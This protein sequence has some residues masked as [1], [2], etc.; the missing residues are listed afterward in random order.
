MKLIR[1]LALI[2]AIAA[3]WAAPAAI[4]ASNQTD[5]APAEAPRAVMPSLKYEFDPVVD[6][7]QVTHGFKIRNEGNAELAI[8]Q[9]KT[10]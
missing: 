3:F 7:S 10:G 2:T 5:A 6:G 9:V 1:C 4:G 8:H